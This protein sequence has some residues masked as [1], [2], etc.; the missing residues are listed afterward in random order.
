MWLLPVGIS[1]SKRLQ[2]KAKNIIKTKKS[3]IQNKIEQVKKETLRTIDAYF[4]K[5]HQH[6]CICGKWTFWRCNFLHLRIRNC[7]L[8]VLLKSQHQIMIIEYGFLLSQPFLLFYPVII[9]ETMLSTCIRRFLFH[10]ASISIWCCLY[11]I[12][13]ILSLIFHQRLI[14]VL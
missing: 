4:Q 13:T 6:Y 7:I 1:Q 11:D 10:V 3:A 9:W 14:L 2:R 5:Q 12:N 8:L